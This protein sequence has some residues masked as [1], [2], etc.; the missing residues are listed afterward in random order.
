[1]LRRMTTGHRPPETTG[2]L[3]DRAWRD[4]RQALGRFIAARIADPADAEDVLQDV[5]AHAAAHLPR[6][7]QQDRLH[8]WLY[9]IARNAIT[10][11]YRRR[12]PATAPPGPGP[13][14]PSPDTPEPDGEDA[15]LACLQPMLQ[16]LTPADRE[17]LL[18]ADAEGLPQAA[19]AQRLG[20]SVSG[21][22]SRVQRARRRLRAVFESCCHIDR[23]RRGTAIALA[24]HTPADACCDAAPADDAAPPPHRTT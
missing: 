3:D 19:L 9:R 18:L 24:P 14:V 1:M 4:M 10:D 2:T 22:K 7:R 17:A 11:H 23:D 15:V 12:R 21:A 16:R 8:A 20:L 5:L 13:A 6:L